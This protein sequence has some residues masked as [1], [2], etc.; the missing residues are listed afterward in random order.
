MT[1]K[2]CTKCKTDH[3]IEMFTKNK[4]RK[5]G[6]AAWCKVCSKASVADWYSR[7]KDKAQENI[8]KHY[9]N[10]KQAANDRS[11][12]WKKANKELINARNKKNYDPEKRREYFAAYRKANK[13]KRN[14]YNKE[15]LNERPG[16]V[17]AYAAKRRDA[18]RKATLSCSS[19]QDLEEIKGIYALAKKMTESTGQP[20]H[21]DHVIPLKGRSVCGLHVPWNLQVITA[22]ENLKKSNKVSEFSL[23]TFG[24]G[25][26]KDVHSLTNI[27]KKAALAAALSA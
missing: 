15:W 22:T 19:L 3:P 2:Y 10:N 27:K 25:H 13:D 24:T 20:H 4:N 17:N 11:R 9:L 8:K 18:V 16:L 7:N 14:A 21:V 23:S 26:V 6:L 1:T 12:A 5:D